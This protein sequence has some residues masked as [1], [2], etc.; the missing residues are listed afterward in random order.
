MPATRLAISARSAASPSTGTR[1]LRAARAQREQPLLDRLQAIALELELLPGAL[2]QR[3]R[4]LELDPG[5]LERRRRR[6]EHRAGARRHPLDRP[7]R[8]GEPRLDAALTA[9]DRQ[10]L[11]DRLA[12]LLA[13]HQPRARRGERLLLARLGRQLVQLVLH[14]APIGLLARRPLDLGGGRLPRPLRLSPGCMGGAH[15]RDRGLEPAVGIE[16]TA[17]GRR[18]E[19]GLLLVLAMD[20]DQQLADPA[21]QPA[22]DRLIVDERPRAAVGGEHAAQHQVV[23][24]LDAVLAE[25]RRRRRVGGRREHRADRGLRRTLADQRPIG[26]ATQREAEGVEQDRLAGAGLAGQHA[27]PAGELEVEPLDQDDVADRKAGQHGGGRSVR[28]AR[29][30]R[31]EP[32]GPT[33]SGPAIIAAPRR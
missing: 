31:S 18:I 2:E 4:L 19:Q 32:S 15:R 29:A 24:G 23:L 11:G 33:A 9:E 5:A 28:S 21:Q 26:P 13:V 10:R 3:R 14:V 12:E 1:C 27:E 6:L 17:L 8:A 30:C 7:L 25:Q 20:L 22:A 16:Q